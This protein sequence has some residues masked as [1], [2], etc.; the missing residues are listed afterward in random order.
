MY[1]NPVTNKL[2]I[3]SRMSLSRVEIYSILGKKMNEINIEFESISVEDL[4]EG[5]YLVKIESELGFVYKRL[6]KN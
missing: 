2:T 3:D 4:S 5:I 6:I 1:P